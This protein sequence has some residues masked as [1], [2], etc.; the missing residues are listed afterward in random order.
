MLERRRAHFAKM[1]KD[2]DGFVTKKEAKDA[3]K[4][5]GDKRREHKKETMD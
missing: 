3:R 4:E 5:M 2:G 1:D